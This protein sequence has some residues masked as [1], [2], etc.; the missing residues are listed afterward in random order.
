MALIT[1]TGFVII[2]ITTGFD[3]EKLDVSWLTFD[4]VNWREANPKRIFS[5]IVE[6]GSH[7]FDLAIRE[8]ITNS[9]GEEDEIIKGYLPQSKEQ[10]YELL[11]TLSVNDADFASIQWTV[12]EEAGEPDE[13]VQQWQSERRMQ[14]GDKVIFFHDDEWVTYEITRDH[15]SQRGWEPPRANTFFRVWEP[16]S[17]TPEPWTQPIAGDGRYKWSAVV[18]HKERIW[19]NDFDPAGTKDPE[20]EVWLNVWEPGEFAGWTDL[21]PI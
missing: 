14:E 6:S 18:T 16:P 1:N 17:L 2:S 9:Q 4:T 15:I 10:A 7:T 5:G 20:S 13:I 11:K 19:R 21:G 12:T 8:T 3:N